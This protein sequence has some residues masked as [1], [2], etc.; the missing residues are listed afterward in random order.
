MNWDGFGA[1]QTA[2]LGVLRCRL[3]L[4]QPICAPPTRATDAVLLR[5]FPW[6]LRMSL[7]MFWSLYEGATPPSRVRWIRGAS[8]ASSRCSA[9]RVPCTAHTPD[10]EASC[11]SCDA[12]RSWTALTARVG[13]VGR[14]RAMWAKACRCT[15]LANLRQGGVPC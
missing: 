13:G 14:R 7:P 15:A 9:C 6:A 3:G 5:C 2:M 10:S 1:H 12:R 4:E 8:E 11:R